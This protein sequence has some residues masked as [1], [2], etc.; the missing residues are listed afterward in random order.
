MID[1][2]VSVAIGDLDGVNGPDLTVASDDVLVLLNLCGCP[3]DVNGDGTVD[4]QDLVE[5]VVN[6]GPC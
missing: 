6:F 2:P 4:V 5:V 1:A 3:A